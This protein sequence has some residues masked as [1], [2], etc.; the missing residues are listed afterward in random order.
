MSKFQI[1]AINRLTGD[2]EA[3]SRPLE[4]S[5][6]RARLEKELIARR[7][8]PHQSHVRLKVHRV[9][10]VQLKIPFEYD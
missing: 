5:E 9:R 10:P 3:I 4:E 2:R 6:A 7:G 8:L 1:T